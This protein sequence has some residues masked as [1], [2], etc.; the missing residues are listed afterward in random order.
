MNEMNEIVAKLR[1]VIFTLGCV[2]C[3]RGRD[4][5]DRMLGSILTLEKLADR[6]SQ[7]PSSPAQP[8]QN[9][10][11]ASLPAPPNQNVSE[12]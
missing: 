8:N 11:G 12:G 2:D 5:M 4:N 3:V 6:L 10:K 1:N 7:F 9:V